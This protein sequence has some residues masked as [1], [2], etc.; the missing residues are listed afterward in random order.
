MYNVGKPVAVVIINGGPYAIDDLKGTQDIAILQAGFPGQAGGQAIAN[1]LT[2]GVVNPSGKLMTT[3]C[4]ASY[5]NGKPNDW[6]AMD[7]FQ[8]ATQ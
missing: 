8:C 2:G 1:I 7:G 6:Y 4:P 3:I 5:V